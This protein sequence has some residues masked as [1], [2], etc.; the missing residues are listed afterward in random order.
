MNYPSLRPGAGVVVAAFLASLPFVAGCGLISSDVTNFDL[1]LPP[2]NF[3]IDMGRWQVDSIA[4]DQYF[5]RSCS[6]SNPTFCN[7]AVQQACTMDCSGSCGESNT[8]ELSLDINLRQPV[9]LVMEK[10]ELRSIDDEPIIKVTIDS[11]TYEVTTN[12]LNVDT[13]ELAIYVAP[14]SALASDDPQAKQIGSI[15]PIAAGEVTSGQQ[16]L[17][18]TTAGRAELINLMSSFKT[19]FNVIIGSALV[20]TASQP[21]PTGKLDAVVRIKGHAGL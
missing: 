6:A 1:T 9:D 12:T 11:V 8:C 7:T 3:T 18:F 17:R 15:P 13:P 16:S 5:M 20:V 4:A 19:P 21:W 10:P 2:K 14:I